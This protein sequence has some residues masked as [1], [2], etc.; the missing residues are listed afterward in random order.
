MTWETCGS[1]SKF[2]PCHYQLWY[3]GQVT[4]SS[5]PQF[6]PLWRDN[7]QRLWWRLREAV[8]MKCLE[9]MRFRHGKFS[10][11]GSCYCKDGVSCSWLCADRHSYKDT[12]VQAQGCQG[13]V[14]LEA[15]LLK[16]KRVLQWEKAWQESHLDLTVFALGSF[17][18]Q[19]PQSAQAFFYHLIR[20]NTY[21]HRLYLIKSWV[22]WAIY[23]ESQTSAVRIYQFLLLRQT[24]SAP[25]KYFKK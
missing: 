22:Y 19:Q 21:A 10:A 16:A 14:V 3:L 6:L 5:E 7:F 13:D 8:Y 18:R 20:Q 2:W 11:V 25:N 9:C 24:F 4:L 15:G 17:P 12:W 23:H 1:G